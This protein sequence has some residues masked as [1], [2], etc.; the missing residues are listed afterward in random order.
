MELPRKEL[1][2]SKG[3]EEKERAREVG[4]GVERG[5]RRA[6]RVEDGDRLPPDLARVDAKLLEERRLVLEGCAGATDTDWTRVEGRRGG[7]GGRGGGDV[8]RHEGERVGGGR[9]GGARRRERGRRGGP[10]ARGRMAAVRR[11]GRREDHRRHRELLRHG[12]G[13][14]G[15]SGGGRRW[16]GLEIWEVAG[17]RA[18]GFWPWRGG[19]GSGVE[20]PNRAAQLRDGNGQRYLSFGFR[21]LLFRVFFLL[22]RFVVKQRGKCVVLLLGCFGGKDLIFWSF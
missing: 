14:R 17:D 11:G 9:G 15:E 20:S 2:E 18:V 4:V 5:V 10:H 19:R 3:E 22:A 21:V 16:R 6:E 13:D 8:E 12:R 1:E 7:G